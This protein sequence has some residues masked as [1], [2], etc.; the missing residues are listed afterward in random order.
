[1]WDTK[2]NAEPTGGAP[3]GNHNAAK[4]KR[5]EAALERAFAAWPN[6]PDM[7][8]CSPLM[9]GLNTAA[10]GFVKKVM[11]ERDIAFYRET[12]DRLDGKPAQAVTLAG[13]PESPLRLVIEK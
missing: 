9:I 11:E 2:Q 5:W 1:M 12:G 4:A 13:D 10:H 3:L 6:E 8:D 7:T